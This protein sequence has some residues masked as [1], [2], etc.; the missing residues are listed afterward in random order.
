MFGSAILSPF[1]VAILVV[2]H[3]DWPL[4]LDKDIFTVILHLSNIN[5]HFDASKCQTKKEREQKSTSQ[6]VNKN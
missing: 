5:H 6:G 3:K 4:S 2:C 1:M